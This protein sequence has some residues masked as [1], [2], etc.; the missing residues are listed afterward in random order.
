MKFREMKQ[1]CIQKYIELW[2]NEWVEPRKPSMW[3][4]YSDEDE[5]GILKYSICQGDKLLEPPASTEFDVYLSHDPPQHC[6]E[7][8]C[9]MK[10]GEIEVIDHR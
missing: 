9:N 5:D 10:T 4:C 8:K 6:T 3:E 1:K 2:G 7:F